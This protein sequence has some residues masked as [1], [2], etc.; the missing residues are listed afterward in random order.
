MRMRKIGLSSSSELEFRS[1]FDELRVSGIPYPMRPFPL[2]LSPSKH[3]RTVHRRTGWVRAHTRAALVGALVLLCAACA[4]AGSTFTGRVVAV[5]DGDT[6]SVLRD[7]RAERIRLAG[8]DCP[9]RGQAFGTRAR[10]ATS[11]WAYGQYVTVLVRDRDDYGRLVGDV[12]LPDGRMLNGELVRAGLAWAS[13]YRGGNAEFERLEAEARAARRGLW[14]D[15]H[16]VPPWRY[17]RA[18]PRP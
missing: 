7:G 5:T 9:E 3:E 15:P 18:H 1:P 11:E 10:Q 12:V 2:V 4:V 14:S 6:I 16:A 13:R 17:R 8:I